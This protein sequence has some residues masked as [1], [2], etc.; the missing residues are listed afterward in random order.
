VDSSYSVPN[1][2]KGY[3]RNRD[4][5]SEISC[6]LAARKLDGTSAA[7]YPLK[8]VERESQLLLV[9]PPAWEITS[10]LAVQPRFATLR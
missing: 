2:A 3:F 4:I 8:Q 5:L 10:P 1:G 7:F 9:K 6:A